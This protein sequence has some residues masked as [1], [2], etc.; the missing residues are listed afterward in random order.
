LS[1]APISAP[2]PSLS[3]LWYTHMEFFTRFIPYLQ[4]MM[5][6]IPYIVMIPFTIR[7]RHRPLVVVRDIC[8][9]LFGLSSRTTILQYGYTPIRS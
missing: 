3:I 9:V 5:G 4:C 1:F 7:F 6:Y 8:V 2:P